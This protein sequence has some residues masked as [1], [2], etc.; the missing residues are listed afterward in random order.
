MAYD[1]S[2]GKFHT[3]KSAVVNVDSSTVN[4]LSTAAKH[5]TKCRCG[6]GASSS[7]AESQGRKFC[8]INPGHVPSRCACYKAMQPCGTSCG[9]KSCGNPYG[10]STEAKAGLGRKTSS[11]TRHVLQQYSTGTKGREYMLSKGESP[12]SPPW[13]ARETCLLECIVD[14]MIE[15]GVELS[16]EAMHT[17]YNNISKTCST[18]E[19]TYASKSKDRIAGKFQQIMKQAR[20]YKILYSKQI[21]LNCEAEREPKRS[22]FTIWI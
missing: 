22:R 18:K 13:N 21:E 7:E 2:T 10:T 6:R 1:F 9:C 3:T 20:K 17:A 19:R 8:Q 15:K 5:A 11:R 16:T 4:P 14:E 12:L